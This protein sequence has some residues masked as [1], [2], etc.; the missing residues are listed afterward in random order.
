MEVSRDARLCFIGLLNFCDDRG[1]HP[2]SPRT[3]KAE[4]FPSDDL[5]ADVVASLVSELIRQGLVGAFEADGKPYWFVTGWAR[6]QRIDRPTFKHPAPPDSVN[7]RVGLDDSSTTVRRAIGER[8]TPEGN[9]V[10]GSNTCAVE[11]HDDEPPGFADCWN[12]YPR[13]EGGNP[14]KPAMKAFRARVR[15]GVSPAELLA[16]TERYAAFIRA[17]GQ[18]GTSFVKQAATFFGPDEHWREPWDVADQGGDGIAD[19][20]FLGAL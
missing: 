12:S 9:G 14:R 20:P 19:N 13:R 5:T 4:V 16:G 15:Q 18:E 10:E 1:V 7:S 3:L 2:A 8:S 6:H 17:K 11:H